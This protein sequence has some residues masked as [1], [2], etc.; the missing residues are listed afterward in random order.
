MLY[1]S[2]CFEISDSQTVSVKCVFLLPVLY[3]IQQWKLA[4][5]ASWTCSGFPVYC[6]IEIYSQDAE[7]LC[8]GFQ[9]P[10][11]LVCTL[12]IS[13]VLIVWVSLLLFC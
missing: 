11:R 1:S 13:S 10:V 8:A 12:A 2:V 6:H 3:S 5:R 9:Y 7:Y 4:S